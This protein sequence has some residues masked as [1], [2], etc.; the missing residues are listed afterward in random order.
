[1]ERVGRRDTCLQCGT[2]LHCCLNCAF[3]HATAHNQCREP[4]AEPQ[5]DKQAG[6]FCDYFNF[7]AGR[8]AAAAATTARAKLDALFKNK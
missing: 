6:N 2:D 3:Y 8:R 7:R 4:Q 5:V 1:M